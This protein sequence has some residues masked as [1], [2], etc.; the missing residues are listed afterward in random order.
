MCTLLQEKK[1]VARKPYEC[2]ACYWI[3][4]AGNWGWLS[5]AERRIVVKA[6]QNGWKIQPGETYIYQ[7]LVEGSERWS[8]RA[9]PEMHEICEKYDLYPE[10]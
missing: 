3:R 8:F 10:C 2:Q 9:I 6:K 4:E 7:F 5:F 1:H